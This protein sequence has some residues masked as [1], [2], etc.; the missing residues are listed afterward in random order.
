MAEMCQAALKLGMDE[1]AI[2]DHADFEPLDVCC[3]YFDPEPYWAEIARCRQAFAG[4]LTI[5]AGI[6][7]GESHVY[8]R[9]VAAILAAGDYDLVL[10]SLHWAGERPTFDG[11]FFNGLGLDQG[12]ALYFDHLGRLAEEG[13]YDVLAHIDIIRRAA[14]RRFGPGRFALWTHEDRVRDILRTVARRGKGIE[15]NT[16]F[17]R[18]GMG[19]PGPS[20]QVLRWFKEEGGEIVTLG[21]DGHAPAE[22]GAA[23]EEAIELVRCPLAAAPELIASGEICDAKSIAGLLLALRRTGELPG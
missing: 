21:S 7:C 8:R 5:R 6:E 22:V 23:F 4:R 1:I 3:G 13:D 19:A 20:A 2:T 16:S 14:H 18:K 10:G 11:A 17:Q 9:Q 12:L 15:V